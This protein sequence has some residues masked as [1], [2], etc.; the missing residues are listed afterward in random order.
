[1]GIL[2]DFDK[3]KLDALRT[4]SYDEFGSKGPAIQKKFG[5][6]YNAITSRL[7][8]LERFAKIVISKPGLKFQGNQA[9]LQQVETLNNLRKGKFK[10]KEDLAA[11]KKKA[12]STVLSNAAT[13]ASI[14]AQVPLNGTG[15]H[16]IKG[17]VPTGYLQGSTPREGS[18]RAFLLEQGDL[19]G[20]INA[21]ALAQNGAIVPN[22]IDSQFYEDQ[23][24]KTPGRDENDQSS[25]TSKLSEVPL[26]G[27]EYPRYKDSRKNPSFSADGSPKVNKATNTEVKNGIV[28]NDGI[29]KSLKKPYDTTKSET[30]GITNLR[31]NDGNAA[32]PGRTINSTSK[33]DVDENTREPYNYKSPSFEERDAPY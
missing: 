30:E 9:L 18:L 14:L 19:G 5:N 7:T 27:D 24:A 20:G 21:A 28:S 33:A 6:D 1:M 16:F 2:K 8:D 3:G 25:E 10:D 32:N 12:I 22:N 23:K 26:E 13:T 11:L 17:L 31:R 15:T 29:E 4:L